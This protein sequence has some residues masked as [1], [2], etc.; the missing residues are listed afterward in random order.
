[1]A[2]MQFTPNVPVEI[3]LKFTDGKSV[4]GRFGDQMMYSLSKPADHVVYL[5]NDV[6][7]KLNI[8]EPRKGE[9]IHACKRWSGKKTEKPVWDFWRGGADQQG[10]VPVREDEPRSTSPLPTSG[11]TAT[12]QS[13]NNTST[14]ASSIKPNGNG[15]NGYSNGHAGANPNLPIPPTKIPMNIAVIEAVQMVQTAMKATGEQWSDQSRQDLVSTI[16]IQAGR[17]GW[18]T[19]W[20]R[21]K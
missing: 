8:L 16:I 3:A 12:T 5:D 13:G 15:S 9:V 6:A 18:L 1:M 7:A 17:E 21:G 20:E 14:S 11:P 4:E 19:I 2:I 10:P